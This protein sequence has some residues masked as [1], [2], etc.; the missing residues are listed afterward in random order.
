MNLLPAT[1]VASPEMTVLFAER[2]GKLGRDSSL[3]HDRAEDLFT[4]SV[5]QLLRYLPLKTGLLSVLA[6]AR[7]VQVEDNQVSF[8]RGQG[9]LDDVDHAQLDFWKRMGEFGSPDVLIRLFS[10]SDLVQVVLVEVKLYSGKS[11]TAEDDSPDLD[12]IQGEGN[13]D[14]PDP[15]DP[16]QLVKYWRG[17][18][19]RFPEKPRQLIYLTSHLVP[20]VE[21]LRKSLARDNTM[22]LAW[23]SWYDIWDVVQRQ[24]ET[25]P[26]ADLA[27]LLQCRGFSLFEGFRSPQVT[28][29]IKS[30][31][32]FNAG[33]WFGQDL[34]PLPKSGR[35]WMKG[36]DHGK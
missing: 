4:S 25:L 36:T 2:H 35:F 20:P 21:D 32:F 23:L 26:A 24:R 13:A 16:D 14:G 28:P 18:R 30:A 12:D 6:R 33:Q 17:L 1:E 3:A 5:F 22:N 34:R 15:V 9:E 27:D 31:K 8:Q 11:G 10:G 7:S 19:A 29:T